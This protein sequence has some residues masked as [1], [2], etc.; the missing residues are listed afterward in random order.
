MLEN[1]MHKMIW[2]LGSQNLDN[3]S[4]FIGGTVLDGLDLAEV[5]FLLVSQ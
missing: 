1:A 3:N 4:S 5:D 2:I